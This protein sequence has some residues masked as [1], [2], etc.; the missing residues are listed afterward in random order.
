MTHSILYVSE[1]HRIYDINLDRY[2][3]RKDLKYQV[4]NSYLYQ[5]LR[6]KS[7]FL[8]RSLHR[9]RIAIPFTVFKPF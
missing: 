2:R 7:G 8:N 5:N 1:H 3:R 9:N 4:V 6:F